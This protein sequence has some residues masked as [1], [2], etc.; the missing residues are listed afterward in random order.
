MMFFMHGQYQHFDYELLKAEF[1]TWFRS[2]QLHQYYYTTT[3]LVIN[4]VMPI[5]SRSGRKNY[6]MAHQ[7]NCKKNISNYPPTQ[8]FKLIHAPK[9]MSSYMEQLT[10]QKIE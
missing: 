4:C 3:D 9:I 5:L 8:S 1:E 2:E 7:L 6:K 10:I